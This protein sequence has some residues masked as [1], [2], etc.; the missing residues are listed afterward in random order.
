M[1][2]SIIQTLTP[3]DGSVIFETG[4]ASHQAIEQALHAGRAARSELCALSIAQRKSICSKALAI[5]AE[6]GEDIANEITRQM[7]RPISHSASEIGGVVERANYMISIAEPALADHIP[8]SIDGSKRFIRFAP[9]GTVLLVAPWNYPMLTIANALFPALLAGNNVIVKPS[10][11]TPLS[12]Q[13]YVDAFDAA[14]LPAG[15]LQCLHMDHASTEQL[16]KSKSVDFLCFTGSVN[17]GRKLGTLAA[18]R[19]IGAGLE[20]GGKDPAYVLS[21]ADIDHSVAQLVDGAFYNAG[22][23]CCGIERIYVHESRFE[24]F[25]EQYAD[26]VGQYQ[27]GNPLEANTNLGPVVKRAA[28]DFVRQQTAEACKQGARTLIDPARYPIDTGDSAYLMP[29]V[30]IDVDHSMGIM[31]EESFGPVVGIMAVKS[32]DE[33]VAMM[34]DSNLGLTAS[35][36]TSDLG[37]AETLGDRLQTGTVFMNRC[38][39]LDPALAWTGVKDT[40]VGVSLSPLGF[41]Q[42]TRAKSFNLK[43][44]L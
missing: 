24:Q 28:A 43:V 27:L 18:E 22:Q 38:D 39:Y 8:D 7:G 1:T 41:K 10:S 29:Q 4:S 36:W 25:V 21:D 12:T 17:A 31:R 40:G 9:Q 42:L 2:N 32:D 19:F 6:Q 13:R 20:L 33:A 23:S 34:N 5:L 26:L 15:A 30:L 3:I 11:Q 44:S 35:L 37:L 16:L 14:G